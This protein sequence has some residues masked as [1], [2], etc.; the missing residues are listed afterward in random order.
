VEIPLKL[1]GLLHLIRTPTRYTASSRT[2]IPEANLN[3][4]G[5]LSVLSVGDSDYDLEFVLTAEGY[6][7]GNSGIF[8]AIQR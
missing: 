4:I 6:T 8:N 5:R 2:K 3:L 1:K 7:G